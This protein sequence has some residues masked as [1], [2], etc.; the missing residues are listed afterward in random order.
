MRLFTCR[1]PME[2]TVYHRAHVG[3]YARRNAPRN[4]LRSGVYAIKLRCALRPAGAY[5]QVVIAYLRAR[6]EEAFRLDLAHQE[7]HR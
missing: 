7:S 6:D 2:V 5:R 1:I 4:A 3:G